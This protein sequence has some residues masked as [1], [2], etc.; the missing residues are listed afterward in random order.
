MLSRHPL[1]CLLLHLPYESLYFAWLG[2]PREWFRDEYPESYQI[3]NLV[4]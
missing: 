3:D 1:L 4:P 2:I